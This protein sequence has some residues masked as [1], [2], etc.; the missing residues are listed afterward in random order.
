MDT[1]DFMDYLVARGCSENTL[2]AYAGDL[3]NFERFVKAKG[4]RCTSV[5]PKILQEYVCQIRLP[6]PATGHELAASTIWRRLACISRFYEW[7][8]M[9][10]NGKLHNP[11]KAIDRPRF[12]RGDPKAI[13]DREIEML[14][15]QI[16]DLRDKA[17]IALFISTGL[18]LSEVYQLNRN[19]IQVEHKKTADGEVRVLG[20]GSVIGKGDKERLFLVDR[21]TLES[22][23]AYLRARRDD[24]EPLFI[25]NRR[26]RL[27]R[28]EMQH[29]FK[30]W[31]AKL[32]L[33]DYHI[34]QLRHSYA[35]RLA[36]AGIPSL[37]LKKLM[38]HASFS[39]TQGYFEIKRQ[40]LASEYFAAMELVSPPVAPQQ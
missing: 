14:L 6:D 39:T 12:R 29:I 13:D 28:R 10:R 22:I 23:G 16:T 3:A 37:V 31:C 21:L 9:Q 38:G 34:H 4:L 1:K 5:T 2:K 20:V 27:S 15:D 40:R 35:E 24:G 17:L 33:P 11:V 30:K 7:L 26:Q 19:T 32:K 8:R 25:S 18:R 36:N